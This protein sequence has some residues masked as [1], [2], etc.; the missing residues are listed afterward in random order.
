ML[1]YPRINTHGVFIGC[2]TAPTTY[3]MLKATCPRSGSTGT[4][5]YSMID[6]G[7][8]CDY[9]SSTFQQVICANIVYCETEKPY[10]VMTPTKPVLHYSLTDP[11]VRD[12][13]TYAHR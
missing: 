7:L 6:G 10:G 3:C 9:L 5:S 1:R 2:S 11:A 13:I 8:F 4:R 12:D